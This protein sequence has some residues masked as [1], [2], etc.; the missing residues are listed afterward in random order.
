MIKKK[1]FSDFICGQKKHWF[2]CTENG[3]KSRD[4]IRISAEKMETSSGPEGLDSLKSLCVV[5]NGRTNSDKCFPTLPD[6]SYAAVHAIESNI[7]L[8][9]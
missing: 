6:T 1:E 8:H 4:R 2:V 5:L 9:T 7:Y 3:M